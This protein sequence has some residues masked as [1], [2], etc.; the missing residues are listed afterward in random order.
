MNDQLLV[1]ESIPSQNYVCLSFLSPEAILKEKSVFLAEEFLKS[2]DISTQNT[3]EAF[4]VFLLKNETKLQDKFNKQVNFKTNIR[5]VKVRGV[6]NTIEE[7]KIHASGLQHSDKNFHVFVGQVGYWLPWDPSPQN[8]AESEYQNTQ[9]NE[10]MHE[11]K[12]NR[13]AKEMFFQKQVHE[14][15]DSAIKES[16]EREARTNAGVTE[17]MTSDDPWVKKHPPSPV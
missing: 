1:D 10:L 6:F 2:L 16:L 13:V 17:V 11:Y 7:A 4:K 3:E 15:K 12:K 5:G 14:M 9:L 8:I